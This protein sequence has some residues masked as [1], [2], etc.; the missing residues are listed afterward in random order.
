MRSLRCSHGIVREEE[1]ESEDG[2]GEDIEDGVA[3]DLAV[4]T[5]V[6]GSI[7]NTPDASD[8]LVD[9]SMTGSL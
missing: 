6:S 9:V 4:D 2:L 3:D 7:G 8:M 1:P 5:D